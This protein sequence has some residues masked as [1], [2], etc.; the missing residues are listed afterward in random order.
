MKHSSLA[1]SR[2]NKRSFTK[3]SYGFFIVYFVHLDEINSEFVTRVIYLILVSLS[4]TC[5][6]ITVWLQSDRNNG[7]FV[8]TCMRFWLHI[9]ESQAYLLARELLAAQVVEKNKNEPMFV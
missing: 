3:F 8:K 9:G 6:P 7:H 1:N 2:D 5:R 4:E